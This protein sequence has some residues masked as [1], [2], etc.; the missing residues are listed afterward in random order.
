ML[1]G[2]LPVD[3]LPVSL[4]RIVSH[5]CYLKQISLAR[6]INSLGLERDCASPKEYGFLEDREQHLGSITKEEGWLAG[7]VSWLLG[8]P[9][10][11]YHKIR[12]NKILIITV[13]ISPYYYF[14][15]PVNLR[16]VLALFIQPTIRHFISGCLLEM[17]DSWITGFFACL[18]LSFLSLHSM[19]DLSSLA[20]D[21]ICAPC[22]ESA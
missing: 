14:P 21:Q 7:I 8:R 2:L 12:Q 6:D 18:F 15:L 4:A 22:S 17:G 10:S 13:N 20:R 11:I 16:K 3:F 1:S 19:W 5:A 9:E